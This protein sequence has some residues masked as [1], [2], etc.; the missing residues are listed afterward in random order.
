MNKESVRLLK[1]IIPKEFRGNVTF[2]TQRE[3]WLYNKGLIDG[4]EQTKAIIK[5]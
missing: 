2:K 4:Y 1:A 3:K 5:F